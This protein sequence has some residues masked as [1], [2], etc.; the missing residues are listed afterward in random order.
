MLTAPLLATLALLGLL[1]WFG[2]RDETQLVP[3][4]RGVARG[5]RA[6]SLLLVIVA[7]TFTLA[8]RTPLQSGDLRPGEQLLVP[9]E[10]GHVSVLV[11]GHLPVVSNGKSSSGSFTLAAYDGEQLLARHKGTFEEHWVSSKLRGGGART[12][13]LVAKTEERVDLPREFDQ[14]PLRIELEEERGGLEGRLH[15]DVVPAPPPLPLFIGIGV[16]LTLAGG[17]VDARSKGRTHLAPLVGFTAALSAFLLQGVTPDSP[18]AAIAGAGAGALLF[19]L[20]GGYVART[21]GEGVL[22]TWR[23]RHSAAPAA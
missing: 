23:R 19:G 6:A 7:A 3:G 15:F 16:F 20:P 10:A 21:F 22:Q 8:H 4:A 5:L 17:I 18:A 12:S 14:E 2:F 1:T 9:A 11:Q 13:N